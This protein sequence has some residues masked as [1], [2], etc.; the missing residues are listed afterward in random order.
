[1]PQIV[2]DHNLFR[3][4]PEFSDRIESLW[5]EDRE[6]AAAAEEY[7]ALDK[8]IRGLQMNHIPM[9]DFQFEELKKRRC[10]LKDR[11]YSMIASPY[12]SPSSYYRYR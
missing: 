11:L 1:M 2:E 6:F 7:H 8:Q 12:S 9:S 4:F 3:E 10:L 5:Q